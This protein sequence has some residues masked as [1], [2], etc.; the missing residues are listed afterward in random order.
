MD[1]IR[2][3]TTVILAMVMP[4]GIILYKIGWCNMTMAMVTYII[5]A[6]LLQTPIEKSIMNDSRRIYKPRH[7]QWNRLL[8]MRNSVIKLLEAMENS[9]NK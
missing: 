3:M 9:I 4:T 2:E 1:L 5:A 7:Q 6:L 8:K